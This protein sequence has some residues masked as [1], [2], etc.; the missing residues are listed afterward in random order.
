[1][2][3]SNVVEKTKEDVVVTLS[4]AKAQLNVDEDFKDDDI[5]I[6]S[7]IDQATSLAEDFT[8]KDIALTSNIQEFIEFNGKEIVFQEAPFKSLESIKIYDEEDNE[9]LLEVGT[10]FKIRKRLTEFI[11]M[12]EET[13]EAERLVAEY[14]TGWDCGATPKS[15]VSAIL[16]K[17]NDLYD[18]ERT[19]HTIGVNFR[20]TNAFENLLRGH[21]INRW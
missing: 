4:Q 7:K 20:T 14:T 10:D 21:V 5:F 15:L 9:T 18:I 11:V 1:M 12:F 16:V 17:M 3:Y 2:G 8:A 13:V 6:S 19:S